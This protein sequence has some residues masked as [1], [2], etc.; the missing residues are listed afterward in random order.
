MV[1][2]WVGK[3]ALLE[4][5]LI[6]SK[7]YVIGCYYFAKWNESYIIMFL[8]GILKWLCDDK[9]WCYDNECQLFSL[10]KNVGNMH[11]H[12]MRF[13]R[14]KISSSLKMEIR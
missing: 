13:L 7:Y 14:P 4:S 11:D 9:N 3:S 10:Y 1:A 8:F 12:V 6:D 2:K 5:D